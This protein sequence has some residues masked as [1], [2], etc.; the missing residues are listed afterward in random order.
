MKK[1]YTVGLMIALAKL[2]TIDVCGPLYGQFPPIGNNKN[3]NSG[4]TNGSSNN[5]LA[6]TLPQSS[7]PGLLPKNIGSL[8]PNQLQM[9]QG[10]PILPQNKPEIANAAQTTTQDGLPAF[11]PEI[12]LLRNE[13]PKQLGTIDVV[14]RESYWLVMADKQVFANL[15]TDWKTAEVVANTLRALQFGEQEIQTK[16]DFQSF[17]WEMLGQSKPVVGYMVRNGKP[18]RVVKGTKNFSTP[19]DLKSVH[20]EQVKGAWVVVNNGVY[21]LNFGPE[22]REAEQ[23]IAAIQRY[24]FNRIGFVGSMDSPIM[25]YFFA[26]RDNGVQQ[27][28]AINPMQKLQQIE[29]LDRVGIEV[30]GIGMVGSKTNLDP[31]AFAI[32]KDGFNFSLVNG[33]EVLGQFGRDEWSARDALRT[34]QAMKPT[35]YVR[36]GGEK[37]VMFFYDGV[38][39]QK[40]VPFGVSGQLVQYD[41]LTLKTYPDNTVHIIDTFGRDIASFH[42]KIEAEMGVAAIKHFKLNQ[43]SQLGQPG[44]NGKAAMSFFGRKE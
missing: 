41:R 21:L 8:Q 43:I 13:N 35:A 17:G 37:G 14:N 5:N 12:V 15:G 7:S 11:R 31:Q 36:I 18:M 29:S 22:R 2:S 34:M 33:T 6:P 20:V 44:F 30:P 39:V 3:N 38:D 10:N 26:E 24:G 27:A 16:N 40:R 42:T 1:I 25:R 9:N 19:I 28:N 32:R 23:A 4:D